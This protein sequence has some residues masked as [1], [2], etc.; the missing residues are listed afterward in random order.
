MSTGR[1]AIKSLEAGAII[2]Y[3]ISRLIRVYILNGDT[4]KEKVKKERKKE[5]VNN[6]LSGLWLNWSYRR[7][8]KEKSDE[9]NEKGEKRN[10]AIGE[11]L[12]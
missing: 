3:K 4:E 9:N 12:K 11:Y 7:R 6:L 1:N 10:R 8:G 5:K 2:Q